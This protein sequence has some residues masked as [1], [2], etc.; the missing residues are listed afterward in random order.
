MKKIIFLFLFVLLANY[1]ISFFLIEPLHPYLN[2]KA[3]F[4]PGIK[5]QLY[6]EELLYRI[7]VFTGK[8]IIALCLFM[9]S[10]TD[11]LKRY[12]IG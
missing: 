2:I 5:E 10:L 7:K 1:V 8:S 9:L 4:D 12:K 11:I 6:W 3:F